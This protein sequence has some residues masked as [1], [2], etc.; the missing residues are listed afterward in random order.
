MDRT[1]ANDID[2]AADAERI[3]G[4]E[5]ERLLASPLFVRSPVLSRLLQFLAEH[6]LRGGRGVP[7]AYAIATEALG[8][9]AD[10]DPAVDSY[11][12]V[13]VGRLRS[14][15]DRYYADTAWVHRLR[16]PQGSYELVVQHRASPPARVAAEEDD[17]TAAAPVADPATG[18][19]VTSRQRRR[20]RAWGIAAAAALL[21][22]LAAW[23]W[24]DGRE[25]LRG[26]EP[27]P[28]L[29][30]SAPSAGDTPVSRAIAR[31]LDGKLRD[32]LRR[33][34]LVDLL[35]A[36]RPGTGVSAR[37]ADYR[38]DSS[39][40]RTSEGPVDVTLVLNR[41]S[42]QRAIWSTQLRVTD[43]Q[44]PEFGTLAPAIAQIA[45]DYGIIVRDQV[46]REPENFA[47]GYPCLAQFNRMRQMRSMT[48]ARQVEACLRASIEDKPRDAALLGAL[49]W[50][51]FGDW[52]PRRETPEGKAA[53][54]EARRLARAAYENAPNS[55]VG[56]FAMARAHFYAGDCQSGVAMGDAARL[57][58]P[59]DA[60]IA[61]FLGLFK[62]ACGDAAA[63][64][65][66]LKRSVELDPSYAGVPAV[67]LAFM[68]AQSGDADGALALL[69]RMP[70]PSNLE[71]Q[72][73]MVR[74]I[75]FAR[76]GDMAQAR[77]LWRQLLD[78]TRKPVGTPPEEVLRQFMITPAVIAR[79]AEV[80]R[81][82]GVVSAEP[83]D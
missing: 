39:I 45:G 30:V 70:A 75:V 6:Q 52:Q 80:L 50:L 35:S 48:N 22:A 5:L 24:F 47:P 82:S 37:G 18:A 26:P 62:A 9:S 76:K 46:Q 2:A 32:G 54:A 25:D 7:K 13:M 31:A 23:W 81:A 14:L 60:D 58:N 1:K 64:L 40:V 49:S 65:P 57:L 38:L 43:D 4:E 41:V 68:L 73:L 51:R 27:L 34:D 8:R 20:W 72:Y 63:A 53:F 3:I 19:G 33:F 17:V 79:A 55:T 29:E 16:V 78:Y 71:P 56:L 36:R 15:L 67:T 10:F 59:Y 28:I 66:L 42:D 21:A 12:R 83:P 69:D 44:I 74:A 77:R 11:P 61:G